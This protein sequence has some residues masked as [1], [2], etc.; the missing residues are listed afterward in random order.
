MF[1]TMSDTE[2]ESTMERIPKTANMYNTQIEHAQSIVREN[3]QT[4]NLLAFYNFSYFMSPWGTVK[5]LENA[6]EQ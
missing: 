6:T 3:T 5:L 1:H 4:D 2:V